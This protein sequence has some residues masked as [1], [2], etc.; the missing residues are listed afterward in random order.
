MPAERNVK[1]ADVDDIAECQ[2]ATEGM[3][4]SQKI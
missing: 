4:P 3:I 2:S 1:D